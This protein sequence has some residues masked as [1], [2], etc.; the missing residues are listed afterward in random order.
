VFAGAAGGE[1][2]AAAAE[3]ALHL[4]WPFDR[5]LY[6]RRRLFSWEST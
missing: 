2:I 3:A 5:V 4:D 1:Q 6:R